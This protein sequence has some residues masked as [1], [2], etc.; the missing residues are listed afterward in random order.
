MKYGKEFWEEEKKEATHKKS[1]K[2][3]KKK[4]PKPKHMGKKATALAK[5]PSSKKAQRS[6]AKERMHEF[7]EGHMHSRKKGTGPVVTN[8]KQAVA[9]MLSEERKKG[10]KIPKKK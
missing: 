2:E 6:F 3:H 4:D 1:K 8:P 7:K 9:I 5:H 10:V